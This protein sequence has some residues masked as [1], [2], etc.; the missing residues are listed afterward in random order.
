MKYIYTVILLSACAWHKEPH[1]T[2]YED[3]SQE[4]V[5]GDVGASPGPVLPPTLPTPP[6]APQD[7]STGLSDGSTGVFDART[8]AAVDSG[9]ADAGSDSGVDA[10]TTPTCKCCR[11]YKRKHWYKWRGKKRWRWKWSWRCWKATKPT[12]RPHHHRLCHLL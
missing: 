6:V 3:A 12:C 5:V 2:L 10:G 4:A 11:W 7:A 8:D 9:V 1:V